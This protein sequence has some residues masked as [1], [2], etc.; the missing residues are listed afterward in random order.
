MEKSIRNLQP[1]APAEGLLRRGRDLS[2]V[3]DTEL[4]A[5]FLTFA[6]S[7][8]PSKGKPRLTYL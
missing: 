3:I 4:A 2:Y 5:W 7:L 1:V 6:G 8:H